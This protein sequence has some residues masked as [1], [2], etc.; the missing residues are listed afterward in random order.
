MFT[1]LI[2]ATGI[3]AGIQRAG[4]GARIRVETGLDEIR[5]GDSV[6]VDGVCLTA[7]EVSGGSF[8]ADVSGETLAVS[9]LKDWR[10][11]TRVNLERAVAA[12]ERLG[13]HLVQGHVD[14]SGTI[15]RRVDR[16]G[17]EEV[18]V[19]P[20]KT[21]PGAIVLKGSVAID[22][23]SLT[24]SALSGGAF[25]VTLIPETLRRTTLG[26]KREGARVNLETDIIGKY[27]EHYLAASQSAGGL[28][29]RL[30]QTRFEEGG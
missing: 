30:F 7:V 2:E 19:R 1:G 16:K 13:G 21:L 24:V 23:V 28:A 18:W 12:G 17:S 20:D 29:Q 8:T 4:K 11:G 3:V 22:G 6:G 25:A 10:R 27:V 14:G 26:E 5:K 9:T 15:E